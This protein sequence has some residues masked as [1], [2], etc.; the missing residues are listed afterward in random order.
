[1]DGLEASSTLELKLNHRPSCGCDDWKSFRVKVSGTP[2]TD[3]MTPSSRSRHPPL[4]V[5]QNFFQ[6][7]AAGGGLLLLSARAALIAT[8]T[9]WADDHRRLWFIPFGISVMDHSLPLTFHGWIN[10][11]LV[12]VFFLMVGP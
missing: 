7:E 10:D 4:P 9:S 11:G 1:M 5:F 3:G 2:L 12:A 6:T 8:N